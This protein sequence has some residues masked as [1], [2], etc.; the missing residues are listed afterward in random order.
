MAGQFSFRKELYL[1]L[2]ASYLLLEQDLKDFSRQNVCFPRKKST[3]P[4][5]GVYFNFH[6]TFL[7]APPHLF[8]SQQPYQLGQPRDRPRPNLEPAFCYKELFI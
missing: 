3:H 7:F 1:I 2:Q 6:H 5:I 8:S 4:N